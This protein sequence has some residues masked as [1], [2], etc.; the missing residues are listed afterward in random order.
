MS[1]INYSK[2]KIAIS[3]DSKKIQGLQ[4]G[5]IVRRQY[6]DGTTEYYSLMAVISSGTEKRVKQD[7]NEGDSPYFIGALIDGDAPSSNQI[8]DFARITNLFNY[9]RTGSIYLTAIDSNAPSISAIDKLGFDKS[10]CLPYFVGTTEDVPSKNMYNVVGGSYLSSSYT[11]SDST[12]NRI[13]RLTRNSAAASGSVKFKVTFTDTLEL[14]SKVFVSFKILSSVNKTLNY[15]FGYTDDSSHDAEG[16]VTAG[17][18]ESYSLIEVQIDTAIRNTKSFSID[19]SS[20]SSKEYIE[21]SD[22]NIITLSSISTFKEASKAVF[23]TISGI[24]DPIFGTLKGYGVYTEKLYATKNTS[25]SGTLTAGDSNGFGSTFYAGKIKKNYIQNSEEFSV[26]DSSENTTITNPAQIG[27]SYTLS[28]STATHLFSFLAND[29]VT[30]NVNKIV[31]F[32]VWIYSE[33][34]FS[35]PVVF[36][37]FNDS[38]N[39]VKGWRRYSSTFPLNSF[40]VNFNTDKTITISSPQLEFGEDIS[41]YQPTD[42]VLSTD[43]TGYGAWF[44]KG[45]VGG[46]IQNPL[47]IFP[48]DGSIRSRGDKFHILADGSAYFAGTV[49]IGDKSTLN[50][51]VLLENGKIKADF[52]DVAGIQAKEISAETIE[53]MN[54]DFK[55]GTIGGWLINSTMLTSET[56][57]GKDH[58]EI[59]VNGYIKSVSAQTVKWE[60]DESGA[61]TLASGRIVWDASGNT[62]IAGWNINST[63]IYSSANANGISIYLD[64]GGL[65]YAKNGTADL[66][67][68]DSDGAG[69]FAKGNLTWDKDG[70]LSVK[71]HLEA[72]SGTIA[73]WTITSTTITKNTLTIDENGSILNGEFWKLNSDGSGQLA[74]GAIK[75]GTDGLWNVDKITANTG[76]IGA[77]NI[78]SDSI[79]SGTKA[80]VDNYNSY[81][82]VTLSSK[83]SIVSKQ[84][85]I[86]QDGS[87]HFKG[88]LDAASGTFK[89]SLSAAT[90]TFKGELSAA[91]GTF[92]GELSAATG[93]FTGSV[94]ANSGT[95]GGWTINSTSFTSGYLTLSS[96]GNI[97]CYKGSVTYWE[98]YNDGSASFSSGWTT[99]N[100]DGS[101]Q[102]AN[103]KIKWTNTGAMTID[104]SVSVTASVTAAQINSLSLTTTK[105]TIGGWTIGSSTITGGNIV[106]NS[107]GSITNG[108][109][110]KLNNDGSGQ[111][112]NGVINW[113]SGGSLSIGSWLVESS[114]LKCVN[115]SF[116]NTAK[117]YIGTT[118]SF[119]TEGNSDYIHAMGIDASFKIS[120]YD[121]YSAVTTH[122]REA[123]IDNVAESDKKTAMIIKVTNG[124]KNTALACFGNVSITG[125]IASCGLPLMDTMPNSSTGFDHNTVLVTGTRTLYLP[126][127]TSIAEWFGV[128]PNSG[129]S[130]GVETNGGLNDQVYDLYVVAQP[131]GSTGTILTVK[132]YG[133]NYN[134]DSLQ[135]RGVTRSDSGNY[136]SYNT[137]ANGVCLHFKK[138]RKL[139]YLI[140]SDG[141]TNTPI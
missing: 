65:I 138:V 23:G 114:R 38:W 136:V 129:K 60:L 63:Q 2:Y 62:T 74:K 55:Q 12:R 104:S 113:T 57:S 6:T 100:A 95:I 24:V 120:P 72:I 34:S 119:A 106:L 59:S 103:G 48:E 44:C 133:A 132:S 81:T 31:T 14:S 7:G 86:A 18:N 123:I 50:G 105:G 8:L 26:S 75:W 69:N 51:T 20:L 4:A 78:D 37:T 94:T 16:T 15:S 27:K 121:S 88:T 67:K 126:T 112:S 42:G 102:L 89:G 92:K 21:I 22:F 3:P 28:S 77:W 139:W 19:L 98:L 25:I 85:Y 141:Y 39:I 66:W 109:Y 99:F 97:Y 101:G 73:G 110:W 54:I 1:L 140:N 32:S 91:T 56:T 135:G 13:V 40:Q 76:S 64:S 116:N 29:F 11:D 122:I 52:I 96:N 134:D 70:N 80:A 93:S 33:E 115:S 137:A 131:T 107:A 71:G 127:S 84:F 41:Q 90:G 43:E 5:D 10:I 124:T 130:Y 125:D 68:I 47:L 82:G 53:A 9:D 35:L 87:A 36:G 61:G 111:L 46:T 58:I 108:S 45:G 79:Y 128:N 30:Q 17:T 83:G 118:S 49:E 117:I